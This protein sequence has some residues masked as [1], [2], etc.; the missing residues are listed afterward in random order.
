[1]MLRVRERN[2]RSVI[3]LFAVACFFVLF[4]ANAAWAEKLAIKASVA[5]I[6]SGPGT[7]YEVLWQVEQYTPLQI[8]D[9]DKTGDWY[10][11]KDYE[12]TIG[13]IN[14]DLLAKMDTVIT[15]PRDEKCNVRSGPGTNF[16]VVFKAVKGVPFKVIGRKGDWIHIQHVDG[17]TGWI[18]KMLV[19]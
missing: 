10:Y 2:G 12:G 18:H 14:K 16:D 8:L 1:M 15:K 7:N 5:N 11:V 19:W 17:D 9:K 4:S 6:R 3:L 13:W